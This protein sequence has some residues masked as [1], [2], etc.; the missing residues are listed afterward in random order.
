ML[1][2]FILFF[3]SLYSFFLDNEV[4]PVNSNTFMVSRGGE[5]D[6]KVGWG[7]QK[8]TIIIFC[9]IF[10]SPLVSNVVQMVVSQGS[11]GM[12]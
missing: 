3:F 6:G 11:E 2:L 1:L 4:S 5:N 8:G 7:V 12:S 9:V 10:M